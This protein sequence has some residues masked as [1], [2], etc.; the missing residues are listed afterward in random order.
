MPALTASADIASEVVAGR[1]EILGLIGSGG[2]GTVYRARDRELDELVALKILRGELSHDPQ[3]LARFRRE[4]KLARRVTHKN[5]ARTFDIGAHG[6]VAFLTMELVHG[7]SLAQHLAYKKRL[8][9]ERSVEIALEIARGLGAAHEAGVVH[10]D[11]KPD[12][13][14]IS[15]QGRVVVTDFGIAIAEE[16]LAAEGGGRRIIGTPAYMAPEQLETP[17]KIDARADVYALGLVLYEMLTGELPWVGTTELAIATARILKPPRDPRELVPELPPSVVAILFAALAKDPNDRLPSA[18]AVATKLSG[19]VMPTT[20]TLVDDSISFRSIVPTPLPA[21]QSLAVIR[22]RHAGSSDDDY[23]STGIT[24]ALIDALAGASVRVRA[25]HADLQN[26]EPQDA[27]RELGVDAIV[28]GSL[29][30]SPTGIEVAIRLVGAHDGFALWAGRFNGARG[31]AIAIATSAGQRIAETISGSRIPTPAVHLAAA[32]E[33][34]DLYL[35]GRRAYHRF[36]RTGEAVAL[37][38]RALAKAPD[39]PRILAALA[40]ALSRETGAETD[41]ASAREAAGVRAERAVLLAPA[42]ADAHVA[43][44][45]ARLR[46]G[47]VVEGASLIRRALDLA[48]GHVDALEHASR[49]LMET[50]AVEEGIAHGELAMRVE[51][52]LELVL[53]Y[54][55]VRARALLG[56][57]D[58]VDAAFRQVPEEAA[59]KIA[60]WLTRI[61]LALWRDDPD[62]RKRVLDE[63]AADAFP[64]KAF[65]LAYA[66]YLRGEPGLVEK[67]L[68]EDRMHAPRSSPRQ[69]SFFAQLRAEL[70]L[71]TGDRDDAL[72]AVEA[73][74]RDGLFDETWVDRCPALDPI[75]DDPRFERARAEVHTRAAAATGV[76]LR[77]G[78]GR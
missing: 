9:L 24:E 43:L 32:P 4:V 31:D 18:D 34:V 70:M 71:T 37:L 33:A 11:L 22:L 75:R 59:G 29:T 63:L 35:R 40:L 14:L 42:L 73:S 7:E 20:P 25:A 3:A 44:G 58:A 17:D 23:L 41:T 51:P 67:Q 45:V 78:G 65:P 69:R 64:N 21:R 49:I 53:P 72:S 36:W 57:W 1:Y 2:M 10:R 52:L 8:P 39:D 38:E 61:R 47:H 46:E 6:A 5:I 50:R 55:I 27:G 62:V 16:A 54:Q 48:P 15:R 66:G 74:V 28:S 60:Y 30:T 76:L 68:L 12:N 13:V 19:I 26:R 77:R 56:E